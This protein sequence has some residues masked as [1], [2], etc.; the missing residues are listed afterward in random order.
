MKSAGRFAFP[1]PGCHGSHRSFRRIPGSRAVR[2]PARSCPP[3][4]RRSAA[5]GPCGPRLSSRGSPRPAP[6]PD[7]GRA[8]RVAGNK[9]RSLRPAR[10]HCGWDHHGDAPASPGRQAPA[11]V[12]IR[13]A[14]EPLN[15]VGN[16]RMWRVISKRCVKPDELQHT[17]SDLP[18]SSSPGGTRVCQSVACWYARPMR[19][20]VLSSNPR[21]AIWSESG[22]PSSVRPFGTTSAQ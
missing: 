16:W 8:R 17:C 7:G 11:P 13:Y 5:G 21:Q 3:R 10:H 6:L 4:P 15:K 2:S 14:G 12:L 20:A 9:R 1:A 18:W 19:S 22:S